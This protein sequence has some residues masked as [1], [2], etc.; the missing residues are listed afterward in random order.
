MGVAESV[1][2]LLAQILINQYSF[3]SGFLCP[4]YHRNHTK[5]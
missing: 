4:K 5:L 2:D 1:R 3:V